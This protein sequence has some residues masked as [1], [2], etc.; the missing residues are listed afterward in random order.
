VVLSVAVP[1]ITF[2]E[3]RDQMQFA[4]RAVVSSSVGWAKE[5]EGVAASSVTS[6][7]SMQAEADKLAGLA[8]A[9]AV[10]KMLGDTAFLVRLGSKQ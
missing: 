10:K 7:G 1:E 2:S 3:T 6:T 8:L 9:D 5:Y 4:V